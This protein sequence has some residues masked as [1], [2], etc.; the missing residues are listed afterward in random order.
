[1]KAIIIDDEPQAR[2]ALKSQLE[3]NIEN[4]NIIG[5]A[6]GVLGAKELIQELNPEVIFLD[7]QL[8][9][10][11]G[12]DLLE[13]IDFE[14]L[15]IIF[16]TAYN[17]H[18]IKAFK[19][20]AID[21]LLKPIDVDDLIQT[22]ERLKNKLITGK[23]IK[24]LIGDLK[25]DNLEQIVIQTS[26]GYF[27]FKLLDIIHIT[28]DGNYSRFFF[29]NRKPLLVSKTL[30]EYEILLESNGFLRVHLSHIINLKHVVSFHTNQGLFVTL[31]NNE[32]IPVSH[33]K[34]T[35]LLE[36]LRNI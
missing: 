14:K 27:V 10:G 25:K 28:S 24:K 29:N 3:R 18:A 5:E 19:Y 8:S 12:F 1:M 2:I 32:N 20:N 22:I 26:E 4:L 13:L 30:K 16:T 15:N 33:R 21:Y 35:N 7:I 36:Y 6:A 11:T 31:S 9:D 23:H 17:E 34:K